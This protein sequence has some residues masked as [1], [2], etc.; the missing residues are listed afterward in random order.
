MYVCMYVYMYTHIHG[1]EIRIFGGAEMLQPNQVQ[2]FINT[3]DLTENVLDI[4]W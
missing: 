4:L 3:K 1:K 2:I